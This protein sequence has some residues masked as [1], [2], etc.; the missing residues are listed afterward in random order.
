[1]NSSPVLITGVGKR[2]GLALARDLVDKGYSVIG[3]YRTVYPEIKELEALGVELYHC[4]FQNESQVCKFIEQIR[5]RHKTL[6]ALIHNASDWLPD[7]SEQHDDLA[8][9]QAMMNVHVNVPYQ[10]NK[11]FEPLLRAHSGS[12]ADIIHVTDYVAGVGS[13]KHIAYAA[14]KAAA[15]N[16]VLSYAAKLAPEVSVN[17]IAPA[18]ILFNEDDSEAYREKALTKSPMAREGGMLE[19]LEAFSYL[20]K[21]EYMTGRVIHLDGGRHLK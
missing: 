1:M 4:D 2:V 11:A 15:E 9:I 21:S 16:L 12:I 13:K 7:S 20:L 10:L 5:I 3:S 17:A 18:L 19:M 8:T 14:S 6:R